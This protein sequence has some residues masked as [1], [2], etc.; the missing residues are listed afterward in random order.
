MKIDKHFL[1]EP[2]YF[3]MIVSSTGQLSGEMRSE[4]IREIGKQNIWLAA[5]CKTTC[6]KEE[7][8]VSDWIIL[9]CSALYRKFNDLQ[10]IVAL[11]EL[12]EYGILAVLFGLT[13]ANNVINKNIKLLIDKDASLSEAFSTIVESLDVGLGLKLFRRFVEL[14]YVFDIQVFNRLISMVKTQDEVQELMNEMKSSGIDADAETYFYLLRNE[15][16]ANSAWYYFTLFKK[17]VN[18]D[19]QVNLVTGA[20][21]AIMKKCESK[22]ERIQLFEDFK[23]LYPNDFLASSVIN[24]YILFT[25]NIEEIISYYYCFKELLTV[26]LDDEKKR[27]KGQ[28]REKK[29]HFTAFARLCIYKL[30]EL[31]PYDSFYRFLDDFLQFIIVE[32]KYNLSGR[33]SYN[34]GSVL[35]KMINRIHEF[36]KGRELIELVLRYKQKLW[37]PCY[38]QLLLCARQKDEVNYI[39]THVDLNEIPSKSIVGSIKHMNQEA[40]IYLFEQLRAHNYPINIYIYNVVIKAETYQQSLVLINQMQSD[41]IVPDIQTFQPL[42]RKW[43]TI[44]DLVHIASL[45]S[46]LGVEAD[47]RSSQSIAR[48]ATFLHLEDL[49]IDFSYEDSIMQSNTL[50]KAWKKAITAA[51]N[52]LIGISS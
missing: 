19:E 40:T 23:H 8:E 45:A 10:S 20:Y 6:V 31:V 24:T 52:I 21:E 22:D 14:G 47:S 48:Q 38:E 16:S 35:A 28:I 18:Y 25:D 30:A 3:D 39:V 17:V 43:S 49:L 11:F 7:A 51:S 36:D 5:R 2:K 9:R 42:L 1:Y 26:Y 33:G 50:T 41:G 29:R 32:L 13:N 44:D 4:R 15:E 12:R 27:S 46:S 34:L 37:F